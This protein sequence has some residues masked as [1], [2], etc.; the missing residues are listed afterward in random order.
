MYNIKLIIRTI[1]KYTFRLHVFD[2]VDADNLL[3]MHMLK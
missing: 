3:Y 2:F 1:M